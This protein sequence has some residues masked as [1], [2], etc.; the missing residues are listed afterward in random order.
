MQFK[1]VNGNKF[2]LAAFNTRAGPDRDRCACVATS[3]ELAIS[4]RAV[5]PPADERLV[6]KVQHQ[7]EQLPAALVRVQHVEFLRV[8]R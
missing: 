6:C 8:V 3:L 1:F 7:L 5:A 4:L 2:A